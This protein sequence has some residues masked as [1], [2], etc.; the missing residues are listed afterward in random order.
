[1]DEL[2]KRFE[3]IRL[4]I[5][6]GDHETILVQCDQLPKISLDAHLSD[7]IG[8]LKSRN[9]RQAL[10][11][12]RYYSQNLEKSFFTLNNE[13]PQS[14]LQTPSTETLP[15]QQPQQPQLE[16]QPQEIGLNE[17]MEMAD[18]TKER[19]KE[20]QATPEFPTGEV[21]EELKS[22]LDRSREKR[23]E[24][25]V[26]AGEGI[27]APHTTDE[28]LETT[29][30]KSPLSTSEEFQNGV[31]TTKDDE[32][33][34]DEALNL[35]SNEDDSGEIFA[36]I[37][38][39]DQKYNN[40][41]FQYP[42][43]ED[44]GELPEVVDEMKERLS[45]K[46]YTEKDIEKFLDCYFKF[47]KEGKI[48]YAAKVL[49]LAASTESKFAKFLLARELYKGKVLKKNHSESFN[50]INSLADQNYAEAI[51]DLGQ[52]YEHGVGVSKDRQMALLLYEEAAELGVE[53]ARKLY[54]K[55]NQE[56][57]VMGI[58]KKLNLAKKPL[59]I[60]KSK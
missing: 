58:L 55:I 27:I 11:E 38:Y 40:M 35:L 13:P 49:L 51:C 59:K 50:L 39:I 14:D 56:K 10:Y 54:E 3:I 42:P 45:L 24:S 17:M 41:I 29:P 36:P 28:N 12:M 31:D 4:A 5:Q 20:Y 60:K 47:K 6:L 1:M 30:D 26:E 25:D 32:N 19:I 52:F 48:D 2:I 44:D 8:L 57:G 43:L 15:A 9:Y 53:R 46:E 23:I 16:P 34:E 37:S 21:L 22:I 33:L 18:D 7:I